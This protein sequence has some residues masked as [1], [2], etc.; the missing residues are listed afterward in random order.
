MINALLGTSLPVFIA[1]TLLFMGGCALMTGRA[2][3]RNWRPLWHLLPY[4]LLLGTGDRFVI[5]ALFGGDLT[6]MSGYLIDTALLFIMALAAYRL[7]LARQMVRQ[8]PW[9]HAP[10]GLWSWQEKAQAPDG[11]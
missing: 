6:L 5:Y 9:L 7:T 8:Y 1:I 4:A 2:T 3:A 11:N 10:R